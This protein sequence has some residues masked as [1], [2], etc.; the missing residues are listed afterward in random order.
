[1]KKIGFY[2]YCANPS[3]VGDC[4]ESAV[5]IINRKNLEIEIKTWKHMDIAGHFIANEVLSG[6]D[7]ADFLIADIS[8]LNLNVTYE[9]GYAIGKERWIR[10]FEQ[11][12]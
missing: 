11:L 9:I 3:E 5:S 10:K 4:I 1:M 12:L 6:I 7:E 2:A 8:I